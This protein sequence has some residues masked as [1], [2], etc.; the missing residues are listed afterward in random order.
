MNFGFFFFLLC[1]GVEISTQLLYIYKFHRRRWSDPVHAPCYFLCHKSSHHHI[2][3]SLCASKT[4]ME[5]FSKYRD[6]ATGIA[7]FLPVTKIK[8]TSLTQ[9]VKIILGVLKLPFVLA[10]L[11]L[12]GSI[13]QW[14]PV[15]RQFLSIILLFI[16]VST[17][18]NSEEQKRNR[19]KKGS[20]KDY[21]PR[22][23]TVV[24]SN[25]LSPL[26]GLVYS[27]LLDPLF[28]IPT[29]K[30]DNFVVCSAFSLFFR[31]LSLPSEAEKDPGKTLQELFESAESQSK[32]LI[33]F[34]EGTT[35][36]GRG[37][38][39]FNN[40]IRFETLP[41]QAKIF[42]TALKYDPPEISSP[43][44]TNSVS[45][46]FL[47]ALCQFRITCYVRIGQSPPT[48][49]TRDVAVRLSEVGKLKMIGSS[50]SKRAKVEFFQAWKK[51]NS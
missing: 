42:P 10:L 43:L 23:K 6:G 7:P 49:Q 32:V 16:G 51:R 27:S 34:P 20:T 5:K 17:S 22:P 46:F 14:T 35:S 2:S 15:R 33:I 24:L 4:R 18:I 38:L 28:A 9:A 36:N 1:V 50:L 26:D 47:K 44:P 19:S 30:S 45:W 11:L 21:L 29:D 39:P 12:H 40:E 13:F 3:L 41:S 31:A 48:L 37:L 25:F 8:E